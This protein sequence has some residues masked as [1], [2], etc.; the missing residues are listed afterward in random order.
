MH[1]FCVVASAMSVALAP[2]AERLLMVR[3][4]DADREDPAIHGVVVD[5]PDRNLGGFEAAANA[6]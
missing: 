6:Y 3:V 5:V 2:E 1:I 4:F